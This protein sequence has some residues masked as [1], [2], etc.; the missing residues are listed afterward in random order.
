MLVVTVVGIAAAVALPALATNDEQTL[1]D[2]VAAASTATRFSR[3]GPERTAS[4]YG[5]RI[6]SDR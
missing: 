4:P 6:G 3:A 5:V 2:V 1:D